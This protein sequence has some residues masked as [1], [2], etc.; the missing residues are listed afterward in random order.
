[1]LTKMKIMK[2]ITE[3]VFGRRAKGEKLPPPTVRKIEP[4]V[5][6]DE[7]EWRVYVKFGSRYGTRGSFYQSR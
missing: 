1:M 6:L 2:Y 4:T 3:L 5:Y 7:N